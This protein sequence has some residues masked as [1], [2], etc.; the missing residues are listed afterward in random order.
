MRLKLTKSQLENN[1]FWSG[2]AQYERLKAEMDIKYTR[3]VELEER[4]YL[5]TC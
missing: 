5:R 2:L 1:S 3:M 4:E